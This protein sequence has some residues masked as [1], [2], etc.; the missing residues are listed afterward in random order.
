[1]G[2]NLEETEFPGY[3]ASQEEDEYQ[4]SPQ[5]KPEKFKPQKVIHTPFGFFSVTEHILATDRFDFWL[6]HTNFN[7]TPE[8]VEKIELVDGVET[9]DVLTRYRARIGIPKTSGLFTSEGV[10]L[11]IQKAILEYDYKENVLVDNILYTKFPIDIAKMVQSTIKD[12]N[13]L[14]EYWGLYVLPNGKIDIVTC[15]KIEDLQE[16]LNTY[17]LATQNVGGYVITYQDYRQ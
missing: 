16:K 6:L 10:K 17:N 11:A 4:D 8:I 9:L 15:D 7:L 14:N 2:S 3:D 5:F 12:I 1:L 13:K